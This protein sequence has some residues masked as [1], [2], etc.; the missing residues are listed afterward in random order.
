MTEEQIQAECFQWHWNT[1]PEERQMLYHNNNN[2]W[3]SIAGSRAKSL[4]VV[5]GI[6]DFTLILD[7][8]VMF[9]E[10]KTDTGK[11]KPEQIE[12][13]NKVGNRGHCYF[14]IRTPLEFKNLITK[15][16]GR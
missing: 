7:G 15:I 10:M 14:I 16:Y 4:G 5:K 1:Y 13:M 3:N 2:S 12:F 8:Q 6:S 9:I 11:Q